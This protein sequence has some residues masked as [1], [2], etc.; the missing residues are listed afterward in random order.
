MQIKPKTITELYYTDSSGKEKPL[1]ELDA[2]HLVNAYDQHGL[3]DPS[4]NDYRRHLRQE[5]LIRLG[6]DAK[7]KI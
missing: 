6:S 5:I 4:Q 3:F 7:H 1:R 2:N